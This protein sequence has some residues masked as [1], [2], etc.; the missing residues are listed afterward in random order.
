ML[1]S[2]LSSKT[3]EKTNDKPYF[4]VFCVFSFF[5]FLA[6][7]RRTTGSHIFEVQQTNVVF[8]AGV[9]GFS[10]D[11]EKKKSTDDCCFSVIE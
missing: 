4:C 2:Q 1:V 10:C 3:G 11:G 8:N 9:M 7:P 6:V 5:F